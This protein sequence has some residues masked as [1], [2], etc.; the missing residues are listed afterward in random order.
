MEMMRRL[1]EEGLFTSLD[2][3]TYDWARNAPMKSDLYDFEAG[4]WEFEWSTPAKVYPE[5]DGG[6]FGEGPG[7]QDR[8]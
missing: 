3:S 5:A 4:R 8:P 6:A 2:F 1:G 7:R